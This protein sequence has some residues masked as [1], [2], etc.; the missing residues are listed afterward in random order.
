MRAWP[1]RHWIEPCWRTLKHLLATEACQVQS[2]AA[3][4]GHLVL[5]LMGDVVLFY[6]TRV[7]CKR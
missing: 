7:V 6:P 4:W 3:W 2:E 1:Q 5:R